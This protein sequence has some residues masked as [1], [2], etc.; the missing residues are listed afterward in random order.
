MIDRQAIVVA[1]LGSPYL[2][3]YLTPTLGDHWFEM[4]TTCRVS[5][6]GQYRLEFQLERVIRSVTVTSFPIKE[7]LFA[8]PCKA[9]T[10]KTHDRYHL[11]LG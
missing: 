1:T 6:D 8:S 11:D 10:P 4:Y 3:L 9:C 5:V 2:G 7:Q